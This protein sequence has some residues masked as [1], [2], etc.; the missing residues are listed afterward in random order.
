MKFCVTF[1]T[2]PILSLLGDYS[3]ITLSLTV[4]IVEFGRGLSDKSAS[5]PMMAEVMS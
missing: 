3:D 5:I 1:V 2:K 4:K